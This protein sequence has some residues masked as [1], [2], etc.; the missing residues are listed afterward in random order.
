MHLYIS[1]ILIL[2]LNRISKGEKVIYILL[3]QNL[4]HSISIKM[5]QH[6]SFTARS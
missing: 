2:R 4:I 3:T 6:I 5:E 1:V